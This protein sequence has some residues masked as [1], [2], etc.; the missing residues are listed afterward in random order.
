MDSRPLRGTR[1]IRRLLLILSL[2][3]ASSL[4][5]AHGG[6]L[7]AA[8]CHTDS[9]T[10]QRHC[11][12]QSSAPAPTAGDVVAGTASVID[13]DTLEMHGIKIRFHGADAFESDQLCQRGGRA[14]RC[15]QVA[16]NQLA[17]AINRR[18]VRCAILDTDYYG[19]PVGVCTV[20][21]VDLN[22][23]LVRHGL[24]LAYRQ[25]SNDYVGAE[26]RARAEG[27]GAWAGE[28]MPPWKWR[29]ARRR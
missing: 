24:A 8:G 20:A 19:R 26:Q 2:L 9:R 4:V 17:A 14:W 12:N 16:A 10:G 21:G 5:G 3:P 18:P 22:R 6:G 11:H 15:G 27:R 25:Y 23:W 29:R 13:G 28:F 1:V 7:D